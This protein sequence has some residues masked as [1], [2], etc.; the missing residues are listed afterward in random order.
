MSGIPERGYGSF[1]Q[2]R[3]RW[4]KEGDCHFKVD[5]FSYGS[6]EM[7]EWANLHC[8]GQSLPGTLKGAALQ[9][10]HR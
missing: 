7:E 1:E 10:A 2:W 9:E 4:Q 8:S 3:R 5:G 6:Q